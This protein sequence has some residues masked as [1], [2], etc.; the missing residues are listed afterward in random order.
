MNL[1]DFVTQGC[2]QDNSLESMDIFSQ[3]NELIYDD[4]TSPLFFY[5]FVL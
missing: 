5:N 2:K 4:L 1:D 3:I